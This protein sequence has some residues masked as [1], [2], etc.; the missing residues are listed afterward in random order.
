VTTGVEAET[1]SSLGG[2]KVFESP[3]DRARQA[4]PLLMMSATT[5][6][7]GFLPV[8]WWKHGFRRGYGGCEAAGKA[9]PDDDQ[10]A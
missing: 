3:N 9:R 2:S 8:A 4:A 7:R 6:A 1:V 10:R 5:H